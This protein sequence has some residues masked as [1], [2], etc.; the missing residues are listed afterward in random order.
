M[1]T[2]TLCCLSRI[3]VRKFQ[4][5]DNLKLTLDRP[6]NFFFT[7]SFRTFDKLYKVFI[8]YLLDK[9]VNWV[10]SDKFDIL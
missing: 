7:I 3:Y 4:R 6:A 8:A 5:F 2:Y 9:R 10:L 1:N